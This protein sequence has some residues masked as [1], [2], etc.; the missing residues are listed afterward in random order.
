MKLPDGTKGYA[1][2]I[3]AGLGG[4]LFSFGV[5]DAQVFAIWESICLTL[6]GVGIRHAIK[7]VR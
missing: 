7:K 5:I 4:I 6:F 3:L 1:G 2:A